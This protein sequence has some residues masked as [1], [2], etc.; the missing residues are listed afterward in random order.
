MQ[1]NLY[2]ITNRVNGKSYIG[3]TYKTIEHRF[4]EHI[5]ESRKERNKNRPLH[6][7][8]SK[9]GSDN[10]TVEL[11]GTYNDGELEDR[12]IEA[13]SRYNTYHNGYNATL[14]GDSKRF[15]TFTDEEIIEKYNELGY[16]S[17]VAKYYGCADNTVLLI[18]RRNGIYVNPKAGGEANA[19]R[20]S[21]PVLQYDLD[22]NFINR[23][24][25]Y[26][27]AAKWLQD[28]GISHVKDTA[29]MSYKISL[30]CYGRRKTLYNYI[31]KSE[32]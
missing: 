12:E 20:V 6:K 9:Y 29:S 11:L 26:H 27:E 14:G 23:F 32:V 16:A 13:I 5:R 19:F 24:N 30:C 25:S 31:W 15:I 2:K 21:K 1:G 17:W 28:N 4:S 3:K 10:F 7:A 18:L 22:N 8:I